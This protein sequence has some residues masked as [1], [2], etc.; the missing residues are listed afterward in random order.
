MLDGFI[1]HIN[2]TSYLNRRLRQLSDRLKKVRDCRAETARCH[3]STSC[4]DLIA[5][6]FTLQDTTTNLHMSCR[7]RDVSRECKNCNVY[8]DKGF[9]KD[10]H[11]GFHF[12]FFSYGINVIYSLLFRCVCIL[13]DRQATLTL[14]IYAWPISMAVIRT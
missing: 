12:R 3:R 11:K 2:I 14:I 8:F 4:C 13:S 5:T 6:I 10:P 9:Y 7:I 1:R